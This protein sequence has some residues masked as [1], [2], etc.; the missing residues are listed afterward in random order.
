MLTVRCHYCQHAHLV[1]DLRTAVDA[2]VQRAAGGYAAGQD[3]LCE[4]RGKWWPARV[5]EATGGLYLIHYDGYSSSWDETVGPERLGPRM[6]GAA[7]RQ[8]DPRGG[9]GRGAFVVLAILLLLLGVGAFALARNQPMPATSSA[10][11]PSGSA[12][13]S[14]PLTQGQPV[15]VLWGERWWD[16]TVV[17]V[18]PNDT[19]RVHFDGWADTWDE[20]VTLDRVRVR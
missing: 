17:H 19:V 2:P 1:S 10:A 13:V 9:S 8:P 7:A 5:L 18:H 14:A 3:V 12:A 11:P 20:D 15:S 4:W 6:T 16:A